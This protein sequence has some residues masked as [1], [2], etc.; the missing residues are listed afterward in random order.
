MRLR[1]ADLQTVGICG[2]I[3]GENGRA[4]HGQRGGQGVR[5]GRILR[6]VVRAVRG[7]VAGKRSRF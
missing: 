7:A 4:E 6:G 2:E 5:A 1:R 3:R